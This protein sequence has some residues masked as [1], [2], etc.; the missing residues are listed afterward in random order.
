MPATGDN[1][2]LI[3]LLAGVVLVLAVVCIGRGLRPMRGPGA[4]GIGLHSRVA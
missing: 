3:G 2:T 4:R 1:S